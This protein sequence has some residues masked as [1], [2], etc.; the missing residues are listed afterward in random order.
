[1]QEQAKR[2]LF[3]VVLAIFSWKQHCVCVWIILVCSWGQI[4]VYRHA[5]DGCDYD[6][7]HKRFQTQ[8]LR[9]FPFNIGKEILWRLLELVPEKRQ[10]LCQDNSWLLTPPWTSDTSWPTQTPLCRSYL[11]RK[12]IICHLNFEY[13]FNDTSHQNF[14]DTPCNELSP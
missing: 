8:I 2:H 1:M 11:P 12:V 4:C 14:F 3:V 5:I 10:A 9:F 6:W 13:I 7:C